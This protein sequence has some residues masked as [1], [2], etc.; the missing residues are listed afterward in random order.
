MKTWER[1]DLWQKTMRDR[2]Y[3]PFY[4]HTA[5]RGRFTLIDKSVC[6]KAI[7]KQGI[8]TTFQVSHNASL[9]REEKIV[10]WPGFVYPYFFCETKSCTVPGHESIGWMEYTIADDLFY[11]FVQDGEQ[12]IDAYLI[13]NFQKFKKW[14]WE[15]YEVRKHDK[16]LREHRYKEHTNHFENRTCGL[17][18][19]IADVIQIV[20]VSR[21]YISSIPTWHY[22]ER[23]LPTPNTSVFDVMR[24]RITLLPEQKNI[25]EQIPYILSLQQEYE[26]QHQ[27][28]LDKQ[29]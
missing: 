23:S 6:S 22:E 14:F 26:Y 9:C 24:K 3:I 7:Q 25:I 8:D 5:Y 10:R 4:E 12:A 18:V 20:N 2:F 29:K 19:P 27:Q 28:A 13:R 21:F 11:G 15:M 16:Y 1:D 17:L